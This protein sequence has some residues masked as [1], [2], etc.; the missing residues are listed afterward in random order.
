MPRIL[1]ISGSLRG[2]S[3]NAA[4]LKAAVPLVEAGTELEIASIRGIPLYDGD[5]EASQGIPRAVQDLKA[6]VA[7]S[8][9]LLLAT[10]EYNAGIPGVFKNAID[11]MSR[12]YTDIPKVFGGRPVALMGASLGPYGTMLSQ[13]AWLSTLRALGT[14]PWFGGRLLVPL[15]SKVFNETGELVDE[16]VRNQLR[17][18]LRGFAQF[19]QSSG[20]PPRA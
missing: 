6:R 16:A 8:D 10:P 15:A 9:G 18:F 7:A 4:L 19:I 20:P 14:R 11:W 12:P 13:S 5:V 2:E 17:E 3:Y 1:G